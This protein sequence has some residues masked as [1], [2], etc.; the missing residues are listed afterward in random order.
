MD[1]PY[2]LFEVY[3]VELEYMIVDH[4]S[5]D[6]LPIADRV[7]AEAAGEIVCEVEQG[8]ISWSNEL[9]LH[10]I[11]LKTTQPAQQ[12]Q[13]LPDAFNQQIERIGQILGPMQGR[14][15]PTAMHP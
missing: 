1:R 2:Q 10:V 14:L 15:L 13:R 7:L 3:G 5:L 4:A 12:L 6:V 11:E 8:E 9:A